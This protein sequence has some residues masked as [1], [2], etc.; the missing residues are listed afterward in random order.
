M[1]VCVCVRARAR[2][3]VCVCVCVCAYT[4][5]VAPCVRACMCPC[6]R[7]R[8]RARVCVCV[9]VCVC[10][11]ARLIAYL[12][13][14]TEGMQTHVLS[15]QR[16]KVSLIWNLRAY[17]ILLFIIFDAC[18]LRR[19]TTKCFSKVCISKHAQWNSLFLCFC[20]FKKT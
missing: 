17:R 1:C 4:L 6:E 12:C 15:Q 7:A 16:A 11:L 5:C 2:A 3:R 20:V 8:A 14:N 13:F 18:C 9:P 10:V 19:K